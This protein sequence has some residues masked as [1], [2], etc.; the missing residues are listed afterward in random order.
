VLALVLE[1]ELELAEL[2]ALFSATI[3]C[4]SICPEAAR[5]LDCWN[6]FSADL[7][8]GPSLPSTG[9][10]LKPASFS[11]CW[12]WLTCELSCEDAL[13]FDGVLA[14]EEVS[15]LEAGGEL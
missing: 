10:E 8:F 12:T 5:P 4:E 15:A 14:C 3:V 6:C 7:V 9:P 13:F 1:L 2:P 11:A